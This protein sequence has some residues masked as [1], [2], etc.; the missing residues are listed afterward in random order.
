MKTVKYVAKRIKAN[1]NLALTC[2]HLLELQH[3]VHASRP[4]Y[5]WGV[6]QVAGTA[7]PGFDR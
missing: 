3:A 4:W 1:N 2:K 6:A 7:G 5:D